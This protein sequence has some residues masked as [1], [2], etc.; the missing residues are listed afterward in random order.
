MFVLQAGRTVWRRI[1]GWPVDLS[2]ETELKEG[3]GKAKEE[4][5]VE[6][7][8]TPYGTVSSHFLHS[9]PRNHS[10]LEARP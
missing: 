9:L 3:G 1:T 4:K 2:R 8:P 10:L 5:K 7:R 6:R